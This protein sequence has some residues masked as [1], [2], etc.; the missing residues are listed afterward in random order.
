MDKSLS[1]KKKKINKTLIAFLFSLMFL[2]YAAKRFYSFYDLKV[3]IMK[4]GGHAY[5]R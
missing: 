5:E 3:K 4:T 1:K 2:L